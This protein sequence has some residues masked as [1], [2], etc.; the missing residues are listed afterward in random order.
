MYPSWN[1]RAVGLKLS[2]S[3]TH[4]SGS[5]GWILPASTCWYATS[6]S[7]TTTPSSSAPRM[8]DLGLRGG[9]WPLPVRLARGSRRGSARIFASFPRYARLAAILGLNR[10]GTWVLPEIRSRRWRPGTTAGRSHAATVAFHL[11]RLGAIARVLADH[12][13]RLGLEIMGPVSARTGAHAGVRVPSYAAAGRVARARSATGTRMSGCWSMLS[14]CLRRGRT[15]RRDSCG[16]TIAW[17]GFTWLTQSTP[18]GSGC[19]IV[20][21]LLPGETGLA[22][23]R[24]LLEQLRSAELRRTCHCRAAR[25]LR[26]V[27]GSR[28]ADGRLPDHGRAPIGL[29][30]SSRRSCK[31]R[32]H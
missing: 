19:W 28:S 5:P 3:E 26:I 18:T 12:G 22:N 1:A 32:T 17:S 11:D 16:G 25:M 7:R 21:V 14:T 24:G 8:D 23:C 27:D 20:S 4:R 15:P 9:A 29:A 31:A 30:R 10:T 2:A 6:P 13:S